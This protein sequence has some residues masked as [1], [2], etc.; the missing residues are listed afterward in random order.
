MLV[1]MEVKIDV[2]GGGEY[3]NKTNKLFNYF[4]FELFS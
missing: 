1:P 2:L 3:R 4:Y